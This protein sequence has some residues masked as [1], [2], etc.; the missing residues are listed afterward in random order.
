MDYSPDRDRSVLV[1]HLLDLSEDALLGL[2]M[3]LSFRGP[4][5]SAKDDLLLVI[6]T[7]HHRLEP[8]SERVDE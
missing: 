7:S 5:Q 1:V 3:K 2:L 6:R 8:G 4:E